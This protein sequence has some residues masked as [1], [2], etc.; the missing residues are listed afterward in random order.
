[1]TLGNESR[2]LR[3]LGFAFAATIAL[4]VVGF[5]LPNR[6][7]N[8]VLPLMYSFAIYQYALFLFKGAYNKH[9]AKGGRKGSWWMVIGV[10]LLAVLILIG[11]AF[12]IA[13]EL[14]R[15]FAGK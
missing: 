15:L 4:L 10:S 6:F 2:A 1:M 8:V 12:A 7:P 13:F 14:P 5:Y 9:L 3:T 11:V